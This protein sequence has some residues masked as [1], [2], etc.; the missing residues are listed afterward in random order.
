MTTN[1]PSREE[2]AKERRAPY[3][4][5]FPDTSNSLAEY[6]TSEEIATLKAALR[7]RWKQL[8]R[9]MR[10]LSGNDADNVTRNLK[11]DRSSIQWALTLI[12]EGELPI[13]PETFS[14]AEDILAPLHE[15][16]EAA[17]IKLHERTLREIER[18]PIDDDAWSAE[19]RRRAHAEGWLAGPRGLTGSLLC[20]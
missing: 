1:W 4:D 10:E 18:T 11:S 17:E 15:R 19:L 8:G 3:Y 6:A 20:E 5:R 2:W 9:E 12:D 13:H 16:Y 7:K 14:G